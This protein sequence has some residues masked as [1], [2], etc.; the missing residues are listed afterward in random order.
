MCHC[1]PLQVA[2]RLPYLLGIWVTTDEEASLY[3]GVDAGVYLLDQLEKRVA[4]GESISFK[5]Y[6]G[7][8]CKLGD[9]QKSQGDRCSRVESGKNL[10]WHFGR[11]S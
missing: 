4:N 9:R 7:G 3:V 8:G 11:K 1:V 5:D 6:V 2:L 10:V